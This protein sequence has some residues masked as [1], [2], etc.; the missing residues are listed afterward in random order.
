VIDQRSY[1]R[2]NN[3]GGLWVLGDTHRDWERNRVHSW[4][5]HHYGWYDGGWLI[6]DSGYR[7][8]G[9][10]FSDY[11]GYSS[12]WTVRQVQSSLA[13]QGYPL[14]YADGV[15]G[16]ATRN[17]IAEYQ[18]DYGLAVSGR[19]NTPLLVSLGLD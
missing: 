1:N 12:D 13:E 19:I 8:R 7:P 14:G 2:D 18:Q 3:Y 6:I 9:Y 16:P 10:Y 17:A 5:N 15:I 11:Y 4:N